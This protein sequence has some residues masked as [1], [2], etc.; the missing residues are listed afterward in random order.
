MQITDNLIPVESDVNQ[1]LSKQRSLLDNDISDLFKEFKLSRLLQDC[2]IKKRCGH[3]AALIVYDLFFVPFLLLSN[4][5]L[6][7]H[8]QYEKAAS[9]KNRY[10]RLLENAQF[11]WRLF[12]MKISKTAHQAINRSMP[13]DELF[14]VLDDTITEVSGKLVEG[15]IYIYDHVSGKSVL[16][17]QKLIL[18]LFN[19]S[20]FIPISQR[21]CSGKK[22]P[23]AKRKA[24]KYTKIPKAERIKRDSP[25]AVEREQMNHTKLQ[26]AIGQLKE[27]INKGI[28]ARTVLFDSWFCFNSFII[29]ILQQLELEVICQLKNLPRANKYIYK[30][31][32]YS[33]NELFCYFGQS[34]LRYVKKNQFKQSKLTVSLPN[35]TVKMKIVFVQNDASN[36]WH[37]F[38]ATDSSLSSQKILECYSQRWS[39]E[40]FFKNCKQYLNYG[41]EQMSNLDSIIACDALVFMRY[42][43]LSYLAFKEKATFYEKFN[44]LY[45][46]QTRKAFG[47]EF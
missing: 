44:A 20:Q 8:T 24:S 13:I 42:I 29:Q 14:Y 31:K 18:G 21:F 26:K 38:A 45:K 12:V 35:S 23:R 9:A 41:K 25:G 40:V 15:A 36:K 32:N 4:V 17:F 1:F 33:L 43:F 2:D 46:S 28:K 34:K 16:G 39:I 19:G 7:I 5:Y 22:R 3:S 10:Y 6:F 47:I 11:N 30:G 37:A 27:A